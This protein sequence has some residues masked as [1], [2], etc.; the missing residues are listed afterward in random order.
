MR[1]ALLWTKLAHHVKLLESMTM[2]KKSRVQDR[3]K[4]RFK[5]KG[6]KSNPAK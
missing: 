5:K 4:R 2:E 3:R 6:A 1:T